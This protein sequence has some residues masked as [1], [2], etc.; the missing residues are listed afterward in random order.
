MWI[1]FKTNTELFRLYYDNETKLKLNKQ[2]LISSY[3]II[4]VEKLAI[5]KIIPIKYK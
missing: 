1:S 5:K 2:N 4:L 3:K